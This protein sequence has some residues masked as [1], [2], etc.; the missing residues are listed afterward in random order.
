M[1][2]RM[3]RSLHRRLIEKAAEEGVSA[4][5]LAVSLLSKAL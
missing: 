4:N 2:V 1:L 5:E 3:P